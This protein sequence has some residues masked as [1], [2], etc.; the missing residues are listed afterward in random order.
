MQRRFRARGFT[1]VELLV[2]IAIIGVL[3]ALLLPAVQA[4]REASRRSSCQNNLKQLGLSLHN[5]E[6][7]FGKLPVGDSPS[8]LSPL[9]ML[10][11]YLELSNTYNLF[12]LNVGPF[13][14]PNYDAARPQPAVLLCPSDARPDRSQDMGWTN[15]HPNA[16]SW[17]MVNGWDG[18]FGPANASAGKPG[19]GSGLTFGQISDGLSNTCAFAEVPLGHGGNTSAAPVRSDV[20]SGT[21]DTT[22]IV[23]ARN[24]LMSKNWKSSS[25]VSGW[26]WRG[27]PWSE[28]SVWR[29]WYNHLLPPNQSAWQPGAWEQIVSPAGSY[30]SG[31]AQAA[32]CDGSVGFFSETIDPIIWTAMGTRAGAEVVTLP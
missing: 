6:G 13:S 32:R 17:V 19:L 12:N 4:A 30:H 28:G 21:T 24:G 16:G 3:V 9:V 14:Q 22:N 26:R 7:T 10:T 15:Y 31:G 5:F 27:Y 20:F 1:L 11:N 8:S 18:V 23:N 2:V 25:L 29:N